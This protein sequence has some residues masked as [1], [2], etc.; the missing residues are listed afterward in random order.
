MA[1]TAYELDELKF[2]ST[3]G[4][5]GIDAEH[6]KIPVIDMSNFESCREEITEQLW[7]AATEVGFFQIKHHSIALKK[8]EHAFDLTERLFNLPKP[9]KQNLSLKM[10]KNAGWEFKQQVRP[11]TDSADQK[12]SYQITRPH[13]DG[14]WPSK[15]L[16]PHFQNDML[17]FEAQAWQLG[18]NILSCFADKLGFERHF[19]AQAHQPNS[20]QYQSTLRLLHYLPIEQ[21]TKSEE[22]WRAGAH[23]DFD[24]L[25]MVFQQPNQGGLQVAA[26]K[27]SKHQQVWSNVEPQAGVITCNI[28]DML[29]RWS[30]DKLKS[31]LHR[32]RMP[33]PTEN[34]GSRYSMAFF[35]QANKDKIIQGPEKKYQAITAQDY[36]DM[37]I[38]A[39]FSK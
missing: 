9:D 20:N 25:T 19:F 26:G 35:C 12:E 29:M 7:Q 16:L 36:L 32:V 13:M 14:I 5:K 1:T 30:D 38:N 10:G 37:R 39:N 8:I 6:T 34:Q 33:Y 15:L 21:L 28:G 11:S 23:T 2:E 18:M 4:G 24:C 17:D 27:T 31:T 22:H 3:I